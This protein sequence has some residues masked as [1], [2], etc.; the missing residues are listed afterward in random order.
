MPASSIPDTKS[1][2]RSLT[3]IFHAL[4]V[5]QIVL[6]LVAWWVSTGGIS[7][8]NG[9]MGNIFLYVVLIGAATSIFAGEAIYKMK[10]KSMRSDQPVA[11][12]LQAYTAANIIRMA[13]HEGPNL[14]T[15]IAFMITGEYIFIF[16]FVAILVLFLRLK[17]SARRMNREFG[18]TGEI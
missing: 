6:F 9:D 12:K 5:G 15:A 13:L 2:I 16:I 4:T 18:L 1:T 8:G 7:G 14:L 3:I 10:L 17:P 11:G